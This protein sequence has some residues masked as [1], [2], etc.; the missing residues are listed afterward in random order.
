MDTTLVDYRAAIDMVTSYIQSHIEDD[1]RLDDLAVQAGFSPFHFHRI[2]TAIMG[3]TVAEYVQRIRMAMVAQRLLHT[4]E[5]VTEIGLAAGYKTPS[6]F[7]KAFRLR[8]GVSPTTF[9]AM[10][11][12]T[13]YALLI[14]Q[15][16]PPSAAQRP[17]Q[18]EIRTLPDLR[19]LYV[20]GW[21]MIGGMLPGGRY[22]VILNTG[23]FDD[24]MGAHM[25]LMAWGK[26]NGIT[27]QTADN[28]KVWGV[29]IEFS[30]TDPAEEPDPQKWET[31]I[32][33]WAA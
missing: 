26:A 25:A 19:V 8:F 20:R 31:E 2:F 29:N 14:Q 21:G 4:S 10:E 3:K 17:P 1:L 33:F 22:G 30:I 18:P 6:A 12:Q 13:A 23:P 7:A 28:G 11:R 9:R 24:L 15:P 5:P 27:W 32:A 16:L